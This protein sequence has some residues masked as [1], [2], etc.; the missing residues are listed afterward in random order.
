MNSKKT[1]A[2]ALRFGL[3]KSA[4]SFNDFLSN[5]V[6]QAKILK[7]KLLDTN[8]KPTVP[9]K[10]KAEELLPMKGVVGALGDLSFAG[11]AIRAGRASA[12]AKAIGEDPENIPF[13]LKQPMTANLL[14]TLAGGTLTGLG[15]LKLI[16]P[17]STLGKFLTSGIGAAPGTYFGPDVERLFARE[18]MR[19]IAKKF[20]AVQDISNSPSAI[21][22]YFEPNVRKFLSKERTVNPSRIGIGVDDKEI[23]LPKT[24]LGHIFNK[25]TGLGSLGGYHDYGEA[26]TRALLNNT[27]WRGGKYL[28]GYLP[29]VDALSAP[30]AIPGINVLSLMASPMRSGHLSTAASILNFASRRQEAI[31]AGLKQS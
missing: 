10:F 25:L 13:L 18:Q 6:A 2:T 31:N 9:P 19:D 8:S 23:N 12:L 3:I 26:T 14:A 4:I 17:V 15:A 24:V 27:L 30:S 11:H 22:K 1:Y 28:P 7:D 5:P 21:N 29:A 20:D 16:K